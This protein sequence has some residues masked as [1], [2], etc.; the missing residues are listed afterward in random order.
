M[1]AVLSEVQELRSYRA[2]ANS[3]IP[4]LFVLHWCL[5]RNSSLTCTAFR[6]EVKR[7]ISRINGN[8]MTM[9]NEKLVCFDLVL[10]PWR[11]RSIPL[12]IAAVV[13]V[14]AAVQQHSQQ[15]GLV[16]SF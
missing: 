16:Q 10:W 1:G 15:L 13:C 8:R 9:P 12:V 14:G 4:P 5:E 6:E 11:N 2:G 7:R 3:Q